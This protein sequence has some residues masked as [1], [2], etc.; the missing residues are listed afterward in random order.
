M[1]RK[2]WQRDWF[3]GVLFTIVF[4]FAS[5]SNF[6]QALER[7]GYDI[8]VRASSRDAGEH[9]AVVAI[10][11]ESIANLGRWPW[12]R[13]LHAD[14]IDLLSE[15]GAKVIAETIFFSEPQIDPGLKYIR[16]V[17]NF[18]SSTS[19]GSSTL[20]PSASSAVQEL[21]KKLTV[22]EGNLDN[23][24]ALAQSIERSRNTILAMQFVPGDP[25]GNPDS[26][27]PD[28]VSRNSL[29]NVGDA[30]GASESGML[31]IPTLAA[32]AP[33]PELGTPSKGIG[34][35]LNPPDVDGGLR[36]DPLV[37]Q[38][39]G[40]Y[41]P[42]QS[43][44]VAAASLNLGAADIKVNLGEGVEL[45]KLSIRTSPFLEMRPFFY[46]NEGDKPPF[47]VDSFYDVL[48]GKIPAA[49]YKDKIVLIGATA[50]G[51][52]S[53]M[54]T[55]VS[56]SMEPVLIMAH[57]VASILNEDFFVR[58]GFAGV[59]EFF[60]LVALAAYLIYLLPKLKAGTAVLASGVLVLTLIGTEILLMASQAT[61]LQL[62]LP[63]T[64]LFLGHLVLTTK[65]FLVTE[66]S[67][68]KVETESAETN[69]ML[70]LAF[71]QQGQLDMAFE[72]FR[73]CPL[74]DV[75][76]A[77]YNLALDYERK[78]QFNKATSV[79]GYMA[80]HDPGFRDIENRMKRSQQMEDTVMF[81]GSAGPGT[82]FLSGDGVEKPMLGRYEVEKELGKG[83]MGVVYLGRDP[84]INRI[85]AIKTLAL[86]QEFEEDEL[87]DVKERFFREAQTAGRLDHPNI[88]TIYDAG[89]EHDLAYIA[90]EFLQGEDLTP[91]TKPDKLLPLQT[92]LAIIYKAALALDYAHKKNVVHRD[93]K[94]ANIMFDPKSKTLKL[95]DFGI[96]RITDSSKTK[97]GMV[98]GTPSYMSPEQLAGKKVEGKSDLFSLGVMLYQMMTGQLP[99]QGDSMATL[100]Y[101]IANE[102]HPHLGEVRPEL[103]Q[104]AGCLE[105]IIDKALAKDVNKRYQTG[106][107]MAK[108]IH[109]CAKQ[110]ARN[111]KPNN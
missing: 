105:P 14:M 29:K 70:G 43:L 25:L 79:Y 66:K 64:F 5:Q 38:F 57:T 7:T 37:L 46:A 26:P 92:V 90:M 102:P 108:D 59:L 28:Y 72:K 60:I 76:E 71:Q 17:K 86:A 20:D 109:A 48:S 89:E 30:V 68:I 13:K 94:P 110:L 47:P 50:F 73:K 11:D 84:K 33:I 62:M 55:P 67:K 34:H 65:R 24:R 9:I 91:Y 81:G 100:M 96:A 8:G 87:D 58:P 97:T 52:G 106:A 27:L 111:N 88:V 85:V 15:G 23:D 82:L 103:T 101:Q 45:G 54:P 16:E 61:W 51:L 83:A 95:T 77:L 49:K 93:I 99:F 41:Y 104:I 36:T 32:V 21:R 42:S 31:P 80:S 3:V 22:A 63:A 19:L 75:M 1:K 44:L 98:L 40:K 39:Y 107:E 6:L 12:P 69:R 35:L 56:A 2:F 18:V 53:P 78:R 10:D 4:G 74:E